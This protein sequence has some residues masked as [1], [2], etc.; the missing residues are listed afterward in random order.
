MSYMNHCCKRIQNADDDIKVNRILEEEDSMAGEGHHPIL[1][2]RDLVENETVDVEV[3]G[4]DY[5]LQIL[6]HKRPDDEI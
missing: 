1:K 4:A 6:L 5:A 3:E 2:D